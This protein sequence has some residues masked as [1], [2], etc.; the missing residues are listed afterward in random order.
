MRKDDKDGSFTEADHLTGDVDMFD[1]MTT[2]LEERQRRLRERWSDADLPFRP[3][4]GH[5]ARRRPDFAETT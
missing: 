5:Q 3:D 4:H 1:I 2:F